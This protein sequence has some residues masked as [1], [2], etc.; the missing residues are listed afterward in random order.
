MGFPNAPD[1]NG[2]LNLGCWEVHF[3]RAQP[4][5]TSP[6][7]VYRGDT[8]SGRVAGFTLPAYQLTNIGLV[9]RILHKPKNEP[10]PPPSTNK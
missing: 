3:H 2:E 10:C 7:N 6:I 5:G 4:D 8:S 9:T 1:W